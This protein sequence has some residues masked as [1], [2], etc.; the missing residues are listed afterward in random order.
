MRIPLK[1]VTYTLKFI[2]NSQSHPL[3]PLQIFLAC[4]FP[5]SSMHMIPLYWIFPFDTLMLSTLMFPNINHS[6][7]PYSPPTIPLLLT[8]FTAQVLEKWNQGCYLYFSFLPP[9]QLRFYLLHS[10]KTAFVEVTKDLLVAKPNSHFS[11]LTLPDLPA[12]FTTACHPLREL[13]SFSQFPVT[14]KFP[15]FFSSLRSA[16]SQ[17]PL[18][19]STFGLY[20]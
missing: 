16:L 3:L 7:D 18:L 1:Q 6:L 8:L 5:F 9:L 10:T 12:V 11:V 17:S 13:L 2:L 19:A 4:S 20:F 15:R 14:P